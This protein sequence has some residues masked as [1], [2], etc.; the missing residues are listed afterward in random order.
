MVTIPTPARVLRLAYLEG[1]PSTGDEA[2][3]SFKYPESHFGQTR[4]EFRR[5]WVDAAPRSSHNQTDEI[6]YFER[7]VEE[8]LELAAAATH[9]SAESIHL[10]LARAYRARVRTIRSRQEVLSWLNEEG[11]SLLSN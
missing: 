8:E 9:P 5:T 6:R 4:P 7:R 10:E 1:A 11:A 2:V 3:L